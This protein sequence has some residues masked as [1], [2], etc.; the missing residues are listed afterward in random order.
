MYLSKLE[1][2]NFRGIRSARLDF[3]ETTV[4]VGENNS[5]K[6]TLLDAISLILS[7]LDEN[8]SVTFR[9]QDFYLLND[10]QEFKAAGPVSIKLT[11]CERTPDEWSF[12][13][14]NDFGLRLPDDRYALQ[15]MTLVVTANPPAVNEVAEAHW[16]LI[17]EGID[18]KE[19]TD[20]PAV[21]Q[22]IRRLNPVFRIRGSMMTSFPDYPGAIPDESDTRP[23]ARLDA[24]ALLSQIEKTYTSLV[25]ESVSDESSELRAGYEAALKYLS[26]YSGLFSLDGSPLDPA[27]YEILGKKSQVDDR[28]EKRITLRHG[29]AAEQIGLLLFTTAF[30]QSGSL[31]ADPSAEP[32]IIIEDPEANLHPMTL[33][34][35]KLLIERLKWQKIIT[36]YSGSLLSDFPMEEIRRITRHSGHISQFRIGPGVLSKEELRRMNY[37]VRKRLHNATFARCWLLV[38]GESEIWLLPYLAKLCGY[39]LALEGI[40]CVEFAQCGIAPL[41]KSA[42]ELG[43][44]WFLLSDGDSAGKDYFETAKHFALQSGRNME[45]H[46]LRLREKDIEHH[47]FF[48]G[49]SDIY[50]EYSG[51]P[52]EAA[53]RMNPRKIIE[54]A[55]HRHSKPFMAIA[56]IEAI[57]RGSSVGVPQQLRQVIE[58][59][60]RLARQRTRNA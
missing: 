23:K 55:I 12:I 32:I 44:G 35:V 38:E 31:M 48:N 36:T 51:F 18:H 3:S 13:R 30:L 60:V 56:V 50:T 16:H 25:T 34:S 54:K 24:A 52:A 21:L 7:P 47:F 33:E 27:L 4:L 10:I 59:S 1:I 19:T 45:D 15:E 22:W 5:G 53:E 43:I 14:N 40:V 8:L 9:Q 28:N 6:T 2:A 58:R 17:I 41:I 37:H 20:D 26:K 39:D 49:Y 29:S 42:R 11:F 46:C 57:A